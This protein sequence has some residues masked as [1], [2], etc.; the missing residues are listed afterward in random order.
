MGSFP[1][2]E[3]IKIPDPKWDSCCPKRR[4]KCW[5]P[6][7]ILSA[8]RGNK[9][10]GSPC[11]IFF[12]LIGY[13]NVGSLS[14]ILVTLRGDQSVGSPSEILISLRGEQNVGF[15]MRD[16]FLHKGGPN[17]WI[18]K[19]NLRQETVISLKSHKGSLLFSWN[20]K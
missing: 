4:S 6:G 17:Y 3:V 19:R 15:P 5:I 2:L 10:V 7:G 12:V 11:K 14:L 1:P 20:G 13:Q 8:L 9:N 18:P 16:P